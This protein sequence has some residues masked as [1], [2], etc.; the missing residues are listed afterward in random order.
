MTIQPFRRWA[1][2][3]IEFEDA[4]RRTARVERH[5][6]LGNGFS[7]DARKKHF[8]YRTLRERAGGFSTRVA[9]RF[10]GLGPNFELVLADIHAEL[11]RGDLT[12]DERAW[13][14]RD[15]AEV[16][17]GFGRALMRSHPNTVFELSSDELTNCARF[18][19]QFV[20]KIRGRHRGK[21]F[22]TN[23][24]LL[25]AWVLAGRRKIL[26]C[27]D[28][29]ASPRDGSN[30]RLPDRAYC[31]A[32]YLHGALHI[33][34]HNGREVMLRHEEGQNIIERTRKALIR[35]Y[36]PLI[37]SE[38]SSSQKRERIRSSPYLNWAYQRFG[39]VMGNGSSA[40]FTHGHSLDDLDA[41]L[42]EVVGRKRIG[43]V[44][45]G[46]HGGMSSPARSQAEAWASRWWGRR[47]NSREPIPLRVFVY[48]TARTSP[49]RTKLL[50][51]AA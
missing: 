1:L 32:Y 5:L 49:W 11:Q 23:Y 7:I 31:H 39:L 40:L 24:D 50:A 19:E 41:H 38:G 46:L 16:R 21:I 12:A 18:L 8:E 27:H 3:P 25:L 9:A 14:A 10:D 15:E 34:P 6:L 43:S 20:G 4:L 33:Y 17:E 48:D 2:E 22:T 29:F 28:G 36:F 47:E 13:L 44:F 37:V 30:Y 26:R 35:G 45:L 42:L 51:Q